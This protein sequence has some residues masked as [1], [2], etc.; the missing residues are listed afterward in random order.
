MP[1]QI[2]WRPSFVLM[3][4]EA[5]R[6]L[7]GQVEIMSQTRG[8]AIG[9]VG[10][11]SLLATALGLSADPGNVTG[12]QWAGIAAFGVAVGAALFVLSPRQ[13]HFALLATR[14]D[15]WFDR[16]DNY[17]NDHMLLSAAKAH[18][19]NYLFNKPKIMWMQAGVFWAMLGL[20]AEAVFLVL[21]L[22]LT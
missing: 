13:F 9:L 22:V 5:R 20:A 8:R 15:A 4:D 12:W 6:S 17:G 14:I 2:D 7:D 11:G 16:P 21:S 10:F 1:P 19:E 18:E 3:L